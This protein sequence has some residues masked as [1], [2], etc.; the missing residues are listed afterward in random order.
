MTQAELEQFTGTE[1]YYK[2][3]LGFNYTDGVKYLAEIGQAFW[4]L[5]AI[6]SYQRK[7][8]SRAFQ[9]WE[10]QV[11]E[12]RKGVLTMKEDTGTPEL[13]RQEV[14][15]TDFPLESIKIWLIDGVAILPSE[16]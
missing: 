6:G 4:L 10:L 16:Y 11:K 5:D 2:H 13:V 7:F 3:W 8:K 15:Y 1:N 14:P 9:V 12:D